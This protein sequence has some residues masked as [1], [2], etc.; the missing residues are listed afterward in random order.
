MSQVSDVWIVNLIKS[1]EE[2]WLELL[3][4]K[5]ALAESRD[6]YVS[7]YQERKMQCAS[8]FMPT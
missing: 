8:C 7:F 2:G 3:E 5:S 4:L 6:D 1:L